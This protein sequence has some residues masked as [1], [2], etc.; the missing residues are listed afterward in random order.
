MALVTT[1]NPL[2][3]AFT[4]GSGIW[5]YDKNNQAYLDSYSGIG[6]TGLGHAHPQITEVIARQAGKVIHTSNGFHIPEQE[7][8]AEKL[9]RITGMSQAFFCNSGAEANEAAIKLARLYGHSKGIVSPQLIVMHGAF[10][11][12][13][14]GTLSASNTKIQAGF[15]PLL[16]GFISVPF[17]DIEAIKALAKTHPDI[18]GVMLEP[19]QGEGGI[20]PAEAGFLKE[21]S[22]FTEQQDWMLIFDEIQTGNG[23]TGYFYN[24]LKYDLS[25]DIITTAKGLGNG[26]PIGACL[27]HKRACNL[28]KPGNHGSTFGGNPLACAVAC[29][30]L[31]VIEQQS[32][33]D[34]V[35]QQSKIL[36]NNLDKVLCT[37][38]EVTDVRS[39]GFMFGIELDKPAQE[40]RYHGLKNGILLNVTAEKVIR[41]LPPLILTAEEGE[42]LVARLVKSIEGFLQ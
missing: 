23:R 3:I 2:P 16:P 35:E 30:V 17:N 19:T 24:Y 27:M 22:I 31:D 36:K 12:R 41:L 37:F 1:Y 20:I 14:M 38:S 9:T 42:E 4:H 15:S 18:V 8:L 6:V 10:H 33:C 32:L 13:T 21:L 11:G 28:F 29:T 7:A 39:E 40:I 26:I 25:P 5:L 34:H